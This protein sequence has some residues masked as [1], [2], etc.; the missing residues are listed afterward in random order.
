[1]LVSS[2]ATS[3]VHLVQNGRFVK[4]IEHVPSAADIEYDPRRRRVAVP[5]LGSN[6]VEWHELR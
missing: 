1:M 6:R 4:L 3:S 5:L 2:W